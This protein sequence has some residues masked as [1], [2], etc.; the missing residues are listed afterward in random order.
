MLCR[1]K[2]QYKGSKRNVNVLCSPRVNLS[3]RKH[4]DGRN[5][6]NITDTV[7]DCRDEEAENHMVDSEA[8]SAV[9]QTA[10]V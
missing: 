2:I 4:Y 1:I 5:A 6:G 9:N 7:G 3:R 8:E 10:E